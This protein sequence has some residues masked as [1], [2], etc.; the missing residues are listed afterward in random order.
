MH[1]HRIN[2]Q[3]NIPHMSWI[4]LYR[5]LWNLEQINQLAMAPKKKNRYYS[6]W[7]AWPSSSKQ[8]NGSPVCLRERQWGR[9][10]SYLVCC[11]Q[12]SQPIN[13]NGALIIQLSS[14]LIFLS[15]KVFLANLKS[16]CLWRKIKAIHHRKIKT[17]LN[18][19][20]ASRIQGC[21]FLIPHILNNLTT[22]TFWNALLLLTYPQKIYFI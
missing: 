19:L 10:P 9:H 6:K 22:R 5:L 17:E 3:R 16:L 4:S 12:M 8:V 11:M 7:Q 13:R 20:S 15:L 21:Y 18:Y 2:L 14:S 1:L